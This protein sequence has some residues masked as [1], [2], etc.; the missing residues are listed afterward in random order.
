MP[1]LP[2]DIIYLILTSPNLPCSTL[3]SSCLVS[4]LF[5]SVATPLLYRH[6]TLGNRGDYKDIWLFFF[7][8]HQSM[9]HE[10]SLR[11]L[12]VEARADD[13]VAS[14]A[15]SEKKE[16][17]LLLEGWVRP[18][19]Y[20]QELTV[21]DPT[22]APYWKGSKDPGENCTFILLSFYSLLDGLHPS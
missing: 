15:G 12:V 7:A 14:A 18:T 13:Q 5:S 17:L 3:L 19:I 16:R 21:T 10:E 6:V 2:Y 11:T 4:Q 9:M 20:M 1:E 22:N 8:A